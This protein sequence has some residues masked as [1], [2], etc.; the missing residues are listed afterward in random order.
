MTA[1]KY[2]SYETDITRFAAGTGE[3]VANTYVQM[4][5]RLKGEKL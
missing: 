1:Y 5:K 3:E 2:T 4:L